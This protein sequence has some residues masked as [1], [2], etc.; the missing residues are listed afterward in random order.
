MWSKLLRTPTAFFDILRGLLLAMLFLAAATGDSLRAQTD[1]PTPPPATA[2]SPLQANTSAQAIPV[3]TTSSTYRLQ[4]YD[5]IDV[6]VYSEEDLH[7]PARLGSDGTV[8]LPLIGS[9][10]VGGLT[11]AEATDLI[12]K[13]YAA[14]FVKNPSVLVTV[15]QYRKSTFSILGQVQ[16]PGIFEIPE[17]SHVSILEA[18]SLA[19]GYVTGAA[20]NSITVKRLIDGKNTTIK[21]KAGDMAQNPDA[22]PFEVLPG[23][24]ILVPASQYQENSFSILG[25][26]AR[27]GL[28][29]IPEG[30]HVT[31]I[32]A[33]SLAGGYT[34]MAAQN[35][36]TV[37]RMVDGKLTIL[38]VKAADM[39]QDPNLVPFEVHPGDSILVPYRN[40][41][42]SI[43][44]QVQK[45]GIYEIEEG[46][47][48]NI[49]D[50][51]LMA[52]GYTKEAAQNSVTVKRMVNGKPTTLKVRA[53]DMAEEP[54]VVPFEVLPGDIV[55]V[56][57][58]WY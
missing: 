10:Q 41:T 19:G 18:V 36:I 2:S 21:V 44:G 50:A 38:T 17:G 1:Q 30:A 29:V 23:D 27:P 52:G 22:V 9:V 46:T 57:E 7:K 35:A 11:V 40:S 33:I 43:L 25:Q 49:I 32:D 58:S 20:Q 48:L 28:F 13:R 55:K 47:H 51:I 37:K 4:P 31:I 8:L 54:N 34:A 56:N 3:D 15:L 5:L 53:A 39:A 26:I 24:S 42:F 14:G 12:T 16:R 6:D 45:P